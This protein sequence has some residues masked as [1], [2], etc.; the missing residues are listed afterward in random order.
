MRKLLLVI[1]L[2]AIGCTDGAAARSALEDDGYTD[3]ELTG[4]SFF[5]CGDDDTFHDG[6]RARRGDRVVEGVVCCGW[7]KDCTVRH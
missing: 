4:Y 7:L 5:G 2:F 6:F 1:A 3:I